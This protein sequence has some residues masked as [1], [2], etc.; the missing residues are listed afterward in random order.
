MMRATRPQKAIPG[1]YLVE[2][3]HDQIVAVWGKHPSIEITLRWMQ[4][5]QGYLG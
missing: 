2:A 3:F 5:M 4:A 1:Q